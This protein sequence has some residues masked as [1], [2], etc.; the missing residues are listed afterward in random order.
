MYG[1][2]GNML[3]VNLTD[4][5]SSV[6][7]SEK[8]F[9]Y[10]GGKGMAN[11]IMYDE[12]PAGTEPTAPENKIVFAVGPNTASSAPTSG[13]I[14]LSSLSPFTKFNA[15]VDAHMGGD[16]GVQMKTAGYD[17]VIIEGK[18]DTPVYIYVQ[19]DKVEIRDASALWGKLT[20][21]TTALITKETTP[22]V[23][24]TTIGPAGENLVN[25]SCVMTGVAHCGGGGI[26]KIFGS[27]KLKAIAFHGTKG[28][29]IADAKRVK[30]LNDYVVGDLMG[31]NNNHVV[32]SV[33]QSWSEYDAPRS[34]WTG[35]PGLTWGAAEGGPIDTG[36][37]PPGQPTLIGYRCMKS[38]FDHGALAEKYTVK[39]T[40]CAMCP[41][42]CYAAVNIPFMKKKYGISG[43]HAN[44]CLGNRGMSGLMLAYQDEI[45][46]GDGVLAGRIYGATMNDEYGLWDNY[47]EMLATLNYF[48]KDDYKLMRQV[49]TE[50]EFNAID[51]SK[52]ETG[53]LTFIK[54]IIEC[55]INPEHSMYN[56]AQGA[57]YV[58]EKYHDILGDDYL[59][60]QAIGLWGPLGGKR[61]HGNE[62][63]GQV[64]LLTNIIYNRD[65][66]CHTV[67]NV[68]GSG[69]PHEL[70]KHLLEDLFGEGCLDRPSAYTPMNEAKA[71]FAKFGIVRQVLHDSFTL[72]NWVWPMTFSP[73]RERNYKGD[74]S[75]EAQYMSAITGEE[76]TEESLDFAAERCIQGSML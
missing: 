51:W 13:R 71:R 68:L 17:A 14:T 67:V 52:R 32:P 41:I 38:T 18:S 34:R 73:R 24:V 60:S 46:E 63:N 2:T 69:L 59:H 58:D 42:R 74:L 54:D 61:H 16:T 6:E 75:V 55:L 12:V 28:V 66:M 50:E 57:Y 70:Q 39:M 21:E 27:K 40:G 19:D 22:G 29:E 35:H 36:E 30:E 9:D 23:N 48:M 64:G 26:G 11:R 8:Y 37:S 3:R 31:S 56:L 5:T 65:G 15:I 76:W 10:I 44:T 53:D 49:L 7:S 4:R 1:W 20:G 47:G 45:D 43:S 33:P 62:S 25:L 72:C